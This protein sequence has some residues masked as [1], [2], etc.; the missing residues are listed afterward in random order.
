MLWLDAS[1]DAVYTV[2][3]MM[4]IEKKWSPLHFK[5][6]PKTLRLLRA[7]AKARYVTMTAAFREA[8]RLLAEREGIR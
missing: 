5:A 8:V 3:T 7:L 1:T 4:A 2:A 6:D